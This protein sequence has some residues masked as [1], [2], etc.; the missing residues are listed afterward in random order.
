[1]STM[2]KNFVGKYATKYIWHYNQTLSWQRKIVQRL[3]HSNEHFLFQAI[4]KTAQQYNL[5]LD[6]RTAAYV[7]SIE[8]IFTTYREAGLAF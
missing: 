8:K 7:N 2:L 5:G 4:M 1:M 6:L 3:T